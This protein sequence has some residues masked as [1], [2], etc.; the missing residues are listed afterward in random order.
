MALVAGAWRWRAESSTREMRSVEK[1]LAAAY[2]G[3][4]PFEL[5]LPNAGYAPVNVQR[6]AQTSA[7]SKPVALL[8]AESRIS[9]QMAKNSDDAGWLQFGM[10]ASESA[11]RNAGSQ[12]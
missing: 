3:Q 8:D 2:T 7:F 4:R 5:R 6:G 10:A 9:G 11:R 1:L 12:L